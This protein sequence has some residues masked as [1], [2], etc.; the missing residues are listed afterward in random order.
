MHICEQA[1]FLLSL[2]IPFLK[3]VVYVILVRGCDIF[4]IFIAMGNLD[5][6]YY[7]INTFIPSLHTDM[8]FIGY[9]L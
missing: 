6:V 2:W 3:L 7:I 1:L 9:E 8:A 4:Q 5:N